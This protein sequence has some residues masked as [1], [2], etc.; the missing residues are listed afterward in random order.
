MRL[1]GH[2]ETGPQAGDT[3][4]PVEEDSITVEKRCGHLVLF[5]W[6]AE[7]LR[8]NKATTQYSGLEGLD[9]SSA[10]VF[11]WQIH[12]PFEHLCVISHMGGTTGLKR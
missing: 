9:S 11:S 2:V 5:Q 6:Q 8:K 4:L 1:R 3:P 10:S 12:F 7:L